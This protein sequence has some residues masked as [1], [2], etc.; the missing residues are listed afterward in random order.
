M[1]VYRTRQRYTNGTV[2]N[3]ITT[4][5]LYASS[6]AAVGHSGRTAR[7]RREIRMINEDECVFVRVQFRCSTAVSIGLCRVVL[8]TVIFWKISIHPTNT[9]S[10]RD[11]SSNTTKGG[12]A[13][14]VRE[15]RGE[16]T[17]RPTTPLIEAVSE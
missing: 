4:V 2:L 1:Y 12:R 8:C 14:G 3:I 15:C 9:G 7:R 11:D 16:P 17:S 6:A 10:V 5:L 13:A